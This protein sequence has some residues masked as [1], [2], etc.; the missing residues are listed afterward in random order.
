[1]STEITQHE[2]RRRLTTVGLQAAIAGAVFGVLAALVIGGSAGATTDDDL[3]ASGAVTIQV[4]ADSDWLCAPADSAAFADVTASADVDAA[5]VASGTASGAA[6]G[7]ASNS[8][9]ND[10]SG[11][12]ST[13]GG[14]TGDGGTDGSNGA[15]GHVATAVGAFVTARDALASL[16]HR[17]QVVVDVDADVDGAHQR[18]GRILD[19]DA[20]AAAG[21]VVKGGKDDA[22]LGVLLGILAQL[23]TNH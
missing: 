13:S 19:A 7:S 6:T 23:G 17:A 2:S 22:S 1:M 14:G 8:D 9:S 21:V 5:G 20:D 11:T 10:A 15:S 3:D 12:Q 4:G 16:V 18:Q